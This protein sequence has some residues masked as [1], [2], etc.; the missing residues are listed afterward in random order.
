MNEMIKSSSSR[1]VRAEVAKLFPNAN[2]GNDDRL[3]ISTFNMTHQQI[4]WLYIRIKFVSDDTIDTYWQLSHLLWTLYYVKVYPTYDAMSVHVGH[5]RITVKK[6]VK[7]TVELI[8]DLDMV[9]LIATNNKAL[10]KQYRLILIGENLI[11]AI[12]KRFLLR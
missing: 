1:N 2:F 12:G 3:Y 4:V 9:S 6:W 10:T 5:H 8:S 7:Y 11:V